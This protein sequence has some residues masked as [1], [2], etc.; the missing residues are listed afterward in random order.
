[1]IDEKYIVNM[2]LDSKITKPNSWIKNTPMKIALIEDNEII[3]KNYE[4][5][6]KHFSDF[7]ILFSND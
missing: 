5:F 7:D 3:R 4:D 2:I 6:F 1:M